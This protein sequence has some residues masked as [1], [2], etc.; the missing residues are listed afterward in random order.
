MRTYTPKAAD[1]TREWH[2]IDA[3]DVRLGRLAVQVAT[4]LRGKHKAIYANHV[5]T[6]DFVIV[7]NAAKVSLSRDKANTKM[8]YRHSGYPGG[9]TSTPFGEVL[10]K[11]ARKAI[12]KAVWG[13]LPK[14]RLGRQMLK[15]LKVYAGPEHPH[16]AQKAKPFDITQI[17]Q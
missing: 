13:M 5:D 2:V 12:E 8:A 15:K 3:T 17:A 16:A 1:I 4:L 14:N 6:G 10:E 11:D 7:I 9:L